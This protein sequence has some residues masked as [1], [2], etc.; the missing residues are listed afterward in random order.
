MIL[1]APDI[2]ARLSLGTELF[3]FSVAFNYIVFRYVCFAFCRGSFS[4]ASKARSLL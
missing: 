2:E 1:R 4:L 3:S